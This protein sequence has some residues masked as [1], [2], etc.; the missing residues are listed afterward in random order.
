M[1]EEEGAG[2]EYHAWLRGYASACAS[3]VRERCGGIFLSDMMA[4]N[5]VS[6]LEMIQAGAS[7]EDAETILRVLRGR[8]DSFVAARG[9]TEEVIEMILK[10][11]DE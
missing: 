1:D 5:D 11:I 3:A 2:V 6:L 8:V 7:K 4:R 9:D 10:E